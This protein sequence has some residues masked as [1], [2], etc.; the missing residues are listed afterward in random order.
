M[1]RGIATKIGRSF[2]AV[3]PNRD[4]GDVPSRCSVGDQYAEL[5]HQRPVGARVIAHQLLVFP[6]SRVDGVGIGG[7]RFFS[8]QN[9][10]GGTISD[11]SEVDF[12]E[13]ENFAGR[14]VHLAPF[15]EDPG[16]NVLLFT[17][18]GI[19]FLPLKAMPIGIVMASQDAGVIA[20]CKRG[21]TQSELTQAIQ[22]IGSSRRFAN[23]LNGGQ[24]QAD[25]NPDDRNHNKQFNQRERS[26]TARGDGVHFFAPVVITGSRQIGFENRAGKPTDNSIIRSANA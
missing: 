9:R 24:Q 11:G 21:P 17:R 16:P 10:V 14:S 8:Q 6:G 7:N 1:A 5:P 23:L 2:R 20:Q 25:Q 13:L 22:A 18:V 4:F 15:A 26:S 19:Q 3:R 12:G